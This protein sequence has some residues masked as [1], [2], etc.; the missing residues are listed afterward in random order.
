MGLEKVGIF[1]FCTR[2]SNVDIGLNVRQKERQEFSWRTHPKGKELY[3]LGLH[4]IR[5]GIILIYTRVGNVK[6]YV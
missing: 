2:I 4:G 5:N 3:R 1:L 6:S